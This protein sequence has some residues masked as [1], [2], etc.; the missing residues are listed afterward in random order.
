MGEGKE[1]MARGGEG[2]YLQIA[3]HN[4]SLMKVVKA[5]HDL[6]CI[7]LGPLLCELARVGQ[8]VVQLASVEEVCH[9]VRAR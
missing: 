6:S 9:H 8:E 7:E 4:A 5:E 1:S 3:I 2:G